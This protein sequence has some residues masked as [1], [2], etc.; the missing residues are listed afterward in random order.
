MPLT[1]ATSSSQPAYLSSCTNPP[2]K[3][4]TSALQKSTCQK[5]TCSGTSTLQTQLNTSLTFSSM[6]HRFALSARH[7]SMIDLQL[8]SA[9]AESGTSMSQIREGHDPLLNKSDWRRQM[10][11]YSSQPMEWLF[12][13]EPRREAQPQPHVP[14][15]PAPVEV[16]N[17]ISRPTNPLFLTPNTFIATQVEQ[18]SLD[19]AATAANAA[20][21]IESPNSSPKHSSSS[22]RT[23]MSGNVLDSLQFPVYPPQQTAQ[24]Y[25]PQYLGF[26]D[27]QA[28]WL[29]SVAAATIPRS[30]G[31]EG[32]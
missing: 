23:D 10:P 29:H 25:E 15:Q 17:P 19:V 1:P 22:S 5:S 28:A 9:H 14:N 8:S 6:S 16:K 32:A 20:R 21:F 2:S 26:S 31:Y 3:A 12:A 18:Q 13:Q 11:D 4:G 7:L 30:Y 27:T 24:E